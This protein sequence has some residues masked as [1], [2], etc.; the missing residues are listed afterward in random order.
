MVLVERHS[1]V[2]HVL[3][4]QQLNRQQR[5]GRLDIFR[6]FFAA[7]LVPPN[8]TFLCC[9]RSTSRTSSKNAGHGDVNVYSFRS[10]FLL[11]VACGKFHKQT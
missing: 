1:S 10:F 6:Y 11:S 7:K 5:W 8:P 3:R 9:L 4:G 2:L